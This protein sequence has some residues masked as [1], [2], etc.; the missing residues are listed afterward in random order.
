MAF[1]LR[2]EFIIHDLTVGVFYQKTRELIYNYVDYLI[3]SGYNG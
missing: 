2:E 3:V 1:Y